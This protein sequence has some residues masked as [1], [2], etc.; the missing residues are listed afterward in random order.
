MNKSVEHTV[1]SKC[2]IV[3]YELFSVF[4]VVRWVTGSETLFGISELCLYYLYKIISYT[5]QNEVR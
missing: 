3:M 2:V 4:Q 1:R 5:L